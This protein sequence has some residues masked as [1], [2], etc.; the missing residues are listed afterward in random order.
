M[1]GSRDQVQFCLVHYSIY[2]IIG[3]EPDSNAFD[4]IT[5]LD[6]HDHG[7]QKNI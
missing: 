6:Y 1:I 7:K 3:F 4:K 5:P 2:S